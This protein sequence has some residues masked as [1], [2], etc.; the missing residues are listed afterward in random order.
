MTTGVRR[1]C[2]DGAEAMAAERATARISLTRFEVAAALQW[3]CRDDTAAPA[4]AL[5]A[6]FPSD[7]RRAANAAS[8][9][10]AA[11]FLRNNSLNT[12]F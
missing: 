11:M 9:S 4:P 12:F 6:P 1:R 5:V 8:G 10:N 3:R 2:C 7:S